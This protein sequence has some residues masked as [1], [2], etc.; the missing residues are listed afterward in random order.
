[1]IIEEKRRRQIL[2]DREL[3]TC[4]I[5]QELFLFAFS[6]DTIRFECSAKFNFSNLR[7]VFISPFA[8]VEKVFRFQI[9]NSIFVAIKD[10]R[11]KFR[12]F[13]EH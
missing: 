13:V 4:I 9:T 12:N 10:S 2:L 1:M 6:N 7:K 11:K 8:F 3:F 5:L